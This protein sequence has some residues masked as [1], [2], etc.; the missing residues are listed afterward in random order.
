MDKLQVFICENF[1]PEYKA[2]LDKE[3]I[4]EIELKVYPTMCDHKGKKNEA[5]KILSKAEKEKSIIICNKSCDALNLI[6]DNSIESITS[7]YCFTHLT[8]DEFLDYLTSQGNYIISLGWLRKWDKHLS[9]MGFDKSTARRF[10]Q[11]TTN[12]IVFLDAN[13]DESSEN[14]LEDLS[15]YLDI[16]YL[17]IPIKLETIGLL[18]KS[19][20][21]EWRLHFKNKET[22][23]T[24]NNLRSQSADYSA[25]FDMLGKISSYTNKREVIGKVKDLFIM[26][27]GVQNFNFW[28]EDSTLIPQEIKKFKLSHDNY[29]LLKK[30]NRFCIKVSWDN[31]LYGILDAGEL[32][33]PQYLERY[34]NL[35]LDITKFLGLVLHN[36]EQ[37]EKILDSEKELKYL[38]F[39]DS[40]TGL[41]NR[42][43]VNR[44]LNN[45]VKE[46]KIIVFMFD[47]DKLKYV[48]DNFG[49]S[50]GDKLI[51]N[52]AGIIRKAFRETDI[53]ARIG[54]DEFTAILYDG[55]EDIAET[56]NKRISDMIKLYNN[57]LENEY[58]NLS[59]SV[60][61][62]ISA[63]P[64]E[65]I[66]DIMKKADFKM[67]KDKK[68]S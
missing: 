3:N 13:I 32:L 39:H 26:V 14:L 47:I 12:Q 7:N 44:L 4:Q 60:G 61:Y 45:K 67:Y 35:A 49:H 50:A 9:A 5:K 54:G 68:S 53:V 31:H 25:V 24:I 23:E 48:N 33:F 43:Y 8:C 28:S 42:T 6:D 51:E 62:E 15:S 52:F 2:V 11:E 64:T 55:S 34:L 56:I 66:E 29:L 16:P 30:E 46:D 27:F 18:L 22:S 36:N 57:N 40:M 20:I 21:Y 59:V 38:S 1:Y 63:E 10:F 19:K 58:L 37:Y 65:T 41:F 17:V